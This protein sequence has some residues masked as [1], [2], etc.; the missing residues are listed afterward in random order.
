MKKKFLAISLI[1]I[2]S[3][4]AIIG[5][6]EINMLKKAVVYDERFGVSGVSRYLD[7]KLVLFVVKDDGKDVYFKGYDFEVGVSFIVTREKVEGTP[8][9]MH[10]YGEAP[11]GIAGWD[12]NQGLMVYGMIWTN[13]ITGREFKEKAKP[14][15]EWIL[16]NPKS[17]MDAMREAAKDLDLIEKPDHSQTI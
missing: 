8:N 4:V 3:A 17:L 2:V 10:E 5:C 11:F 12:E 13:E 14:L 9:Y 6:R 15:V 1:L 16:E 7:K